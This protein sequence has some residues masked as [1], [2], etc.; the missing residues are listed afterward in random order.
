MQG[1]PR[2]KV[3]DEETVGV[4]H[5]WLCCVRRAWLCGIDPLTG[6][7]FSHRKQW[8]YERLEELSQIYAVDACVWAIL[9]NHYHLLLQPPRSGRAM[10]G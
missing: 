4:Y 2:Y 6:Q 8:F 5:C 7:D 1:R 9:A 10:D 3:I